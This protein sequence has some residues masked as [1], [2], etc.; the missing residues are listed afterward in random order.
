MGSARVARVAG[1][2]VVGIPFCGIIG[3]W[4]GCVVVFWRFLISSV[5]ACRVLLVADVCVGHWL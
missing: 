2:L 3:G 1:Y 5:E 4:R